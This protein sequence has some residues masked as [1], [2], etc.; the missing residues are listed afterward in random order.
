[1]T[2]KTSDTAELYEN[3]ALQTGSKTGHKSPYEKHHDDWNEEVDKK[4]AELEKEME[5]HV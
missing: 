3:I 2:P 4:A 5:E 1:M